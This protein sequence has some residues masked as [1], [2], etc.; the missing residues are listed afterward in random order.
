[1]R[2]LFYSNIYKLHISSRYGCIKM[3][4]TIWSLSL[5]CGWGCLARGITRQAMFCVCSHSTNSSFCKGRK[6][7]QFSQ[8]YDFHH[9]TLSRS[10]AFSVLRTGCPKLNCISTGYSFWDWLRNFLQ[11]FTWI[12][13][14]VHKLNKLGKFW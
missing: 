5:H 13:L 8:I 4:A 12:V 10:C 14:S 6:R 2:T 9:R 11:K 7:N 3:S 1:M